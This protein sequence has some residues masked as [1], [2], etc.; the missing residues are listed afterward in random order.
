MRAL[1]FLLTACLLLAGAPAPASARV[2]T[3]EMGRRLQVPDQ[4]RRLLGLAASLTEILFALGLGDRVVGATTWADWPPAARK[5]PRVGSYVSPNLER[6]VALAPDLVLATREGNPPWVVH[7][8]AA[9]GIPVYVTVPTDPARLPA[10]LARLGAVC[11][12]P[13]AGR[14]L[15]AR[16]QA[17]FDQVARRLQRV[18]PR[19]TLVVIG[20]RPLVSVSDQTIN[21]KLIAMAGGINLAAGLPGRWPRLSLE[22]VVASRPEVIIVST[23]ERGQ[24][25]ARELAYWRNL[26]GVG[27]RPGVRVAAVNSDITDRPGPR[28]GLGLTA[29]ARAIHPERFPLEKGR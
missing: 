8:L 1:A 6:I 16:L 5:L 15:A 20:R 27:D 7:R 12:V 14:R 11:G 4:P 29:L 10:S 19:R 23:M 25:L 18:R 3:D 2:V 17:Q 9:A 26:P 24:N 28:L 13:Q 22:Y 21:G